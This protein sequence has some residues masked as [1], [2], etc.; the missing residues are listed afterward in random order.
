MNNYIEKL[1]GAHC[2]SIQMSRGNQDVQPGPEVIKLCHAQ[3]PGPCVC[4]W[5]GGGLSFFFI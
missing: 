2:F 4:L 3:L 1:V 5:G